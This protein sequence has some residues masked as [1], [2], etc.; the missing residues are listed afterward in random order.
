MIAVIARQQLLALRREGMAW[1]VT[2]TMSALAVFAGVLGWSSHR[3]IVRVYDEAVVLLANRGL[4]APSNPFVLK[5]ALSLLSN[6][7]VYVPLIGALV[8]VAVGHASMADDRSTGVARLLFSRPLTRRSYALGKL[9]GNA[10][11]LSVATFACAVGCV[12]ALWAANGAI[13]SADIGRLALFFSLTWLY[14][15]CFVLVGMVTVLLVRSRPLAL[16]TAIGVW[17]TITFAMPQITSGLRPSTALNPITDPVSTSQRFF[18]ITS[19]ARPFSWVEQY[20]AASGRI[21]RTAAAEPLSHTLL[22]T[23]P[24]AALVLSLSALLIRLVHGHDYTGGARD[25]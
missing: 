6:M 3:T 24:I 8:A 17:L 11:M 9:V 1:L 18:R 2:A 23:T 22:R 5:P 20:K 7:V 16:L 12:V 19:A 13:T 14:L 10:V 4:P 25:E 15:M 21:L